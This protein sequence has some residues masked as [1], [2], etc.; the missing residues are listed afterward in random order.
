MKKINVLFPII[1]L[2]SIFS[3][4][5]IR[6]TDFHAGMNLGYYGG[7]SWSVYGNAADFARDFPL[8]VRF[9]IGHI[10]LDPGDAAGARKIFINNATNGIPEKKGGTTY[11]QFDFVYPLNIKSLPGSRLYIG[12]RYARFKGN[13]KYVGGNEDFDVTSNQWGLGAGLESVFAMTRKMDLL[14]GGGIEYY[15]SAKL[16][17]HDTAY[18]PDGQDVNPREDY[19]YSDANAAINQP[20]F[21]FRLMIGFQYRL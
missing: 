20:G 13:F 19:T 4:T 10:W 2:I 8:T 14:I 21:E 6:A 9:S 18:S 17:G 12:P 15:F 5:N 11:F 3:T 1:L 16:K 7:L